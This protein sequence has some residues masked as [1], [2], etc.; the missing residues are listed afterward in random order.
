MDL[1]P[2][3]H[4]SLIDGGTICDGLTAE[5]AELARMVEGW[6]ETAILPRIRRNLDAPCACL[7]DA[8]VRSYRASETR[9]GICEAGSDEEAAQGRDGIPPHFDSYSWATAVLELS[10]PAD[11]EGGLYLQAGC[12]AATRHYV[13]PN[14]GG[15]REHAAYGPMPGLTSRLRGVFARGEHAS[16]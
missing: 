3:L 1:A 7:S 12:H 9:G 5:G 8:F 2:S 16:R 13:R 11:F 15:Q 6:V 10:M 14:R 4:A